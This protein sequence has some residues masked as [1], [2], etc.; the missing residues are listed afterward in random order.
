MSN[1]S[2][3]PS[4]DPIPRI[5]AAFE[6]RMVGA[7]A[8]DPEANSTMA[9]A[10]NTE[11]KTLTAAKNTVEITPVKAAFESSITIL[12]LVRVRVPILFLFLHPLISD[13]ARTR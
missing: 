1:Y 11:I 6:P 9:V 3:S 2:S 5:T 4:I 13:L 7:T 10:L 12:T 8:L